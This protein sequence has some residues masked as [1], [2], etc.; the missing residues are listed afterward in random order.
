MSLEFLFMHTLW[1]CFYRHAA[2]F[3]A[4]RYIK[5]HFQPSSKLNPRSVYSLKHDF[6]RASD[7]YICE[8]DYSECLRHCGFKTIDG[9]VFAAETS[10]S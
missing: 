4:C 3:A 9:R 8:S 2:K 7:R 10:C 6:E 5:K 1:K